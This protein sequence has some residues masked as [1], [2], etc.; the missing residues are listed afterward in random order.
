VRFGTLPYVSAILLM[1]S[2]QALVGCGGDSVGGQAVITPSSALIGPGQTV[3]FSEQGHAPDTILT[4]T[5]N[6]VLGGS[7][8]MGT[9]TRQ[10]IYTAPST[11]PAKPITIGLQAACIPAQINFFDPSHP[12]PGSVSATQNPL[13]ASYSIAAPTGASV[14]VQ[15]GPDT[16]YGLATSS[17]PAPS[18][19]GNTTV[20]VAGMRAS[21]TYHMQA[22]VDLA[23]GTK[24][25][26]TDHA[27][28]TSA[29][30]ADQIPNIVAQGAPSDGVELFSLIPGAGPPTL[31]SAVATDL[32]G[33]VIWYYDVGSGNAAFP[34]KLL[35]NG[36]VMILVAAV[37]GILSPG[38]FTEIL[39][40]DL[41]GNIIRQV[42]D[43]DIP[44]PFAASLHHDFQVLP[45]GH[46][47][48]LSHHTETPSN[49]SGI[50]PGT[51]V[52]GDD[53]IDLD[54]SG[55]V[56]WSWSTF[57]HLDLTRAPYGISDWTHG[58]AILY[59]P[60]D[61]NLI[62]SMRNQ[63]WIIKINYANGTGDGSVLWRFGYQGDFTLPN[64]DMPLEWNYGQ[65][66]PVIMSANSS[67]VFNLLFFNNGNNRLVDSND[68]VC[69]STPSLGPCYSSVPL[70]QIDE[71]SRTG[72]VL[73]EDDLLPSY[74]IC[75]GDAQIL[76]NGNTEFDV[77]ADV[78]TPGVSYIEEVSPS[79]D[80]LWK[81]DVTDQLAYR[82]FR[83]PSLY[84]GQT[85]SAAALRSDV[86]PP[87]RT[88]SLDAVRKAPK[89]IKELP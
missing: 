27:F 42:K 71:S 19:G 48:L 62:L 45:N 55:N 54:P 69:G 68:D 33:N 8:A 89:T 56:A 37:S 87:S 72:T 11:V 3:Q 58:N 34:T 79:K 38:S 73:W 66:Y 86:R 53:I 16:N 1:L 15:F 57:D 49:V 2:L 30:S 32:Q 6:G 31:L 60:D 52:T 84:P 85:W 63:N 64:Q 12:A 76:P 9:I 83:I 59:S 88:R 29:L 14:Y 23:D 20:L 7:S 22:V 75:C 51:V 26:D 80:L 77:A 50:P 5:V 40:V 13:V 46:W 10:G 44:S 65:H 41:A 82:G 61:G 81:L 18:G 67:G 21:T 17:L 36:H 28:T 25:S 43:T 47:I 35:P 39:E 74:S 24:A 4:W 70:F 78:N